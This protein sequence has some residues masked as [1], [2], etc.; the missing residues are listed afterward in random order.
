MSHLFKTEEPSDVG[1]V[2]VCV[3][4]CVCGVCVCAFVYTVCVHM[5]ARMCAYNLCT[6]SKAS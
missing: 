6:N 2:C 1:C 3:C 5:Y 4:V